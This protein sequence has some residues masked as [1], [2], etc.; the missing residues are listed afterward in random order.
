MAG[1]GGQNKNKMYK[2]FSVPDN[3]MKMYKLIKNEYAYDNEPPE[4]Y[5]VGQA[6]DDEDEEGGLETDG[7]VV[8][9][10]DENNFSF[11][12]RTDLHMVAQESELAAVYDES[13]LKQ[14]DDFDEMFDEAAQQ[15]DDT[16]NNTFVR[17]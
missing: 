3:K 5:R 10:N 9:Q 8:E 4:K 13:T 7:I 15:E 16:D 1:A 17:K 6:V 14:G 12:K 11:E 2:E